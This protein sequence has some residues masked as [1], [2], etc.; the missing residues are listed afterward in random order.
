MDRIAPADIRALIESE[1]LLALADPASMSDDDNLFEA[2][3]TSLGS[4]Q[5]LLALEERFDIEV[6]DEL[7]SRE[8]FRSMRRLAEVVN[9]A[10]K[11]SRST[12]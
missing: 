8:S 11:A 7:L 4:V 9:E 2:G 6:P 10:V 12:G 1:A 3:L 5:L